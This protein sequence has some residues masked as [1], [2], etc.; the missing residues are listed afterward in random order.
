MA[1]TKEF[2]PEKSLDAAVEV[3]SEQGYEHTSLDALM[4][5]MG[6][7][8]QSLYDTFGDKRALYLKV[9]ERYR[10]KNH[11]YLR[12]VFDGERGV[13]KAFSR[14]FADLTD[15]SRRDYERGCLLLSANLELASHDEEVAKFLRKEQAAEEEIFARTLRRG[16]K[17]GEL[18]AKKDPEALARFFS[19][20]IQGLRASARLSQDRK[21]LRS[22]AAVALSALD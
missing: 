22:I 2:S 8:R 18:G 15:A 5:R 10:D 6:V 20:A 1:R 7:A 17:R 3:F 19:S 16:R 4:D 9:L 13:K 12:R 21:T 14:I 11:A